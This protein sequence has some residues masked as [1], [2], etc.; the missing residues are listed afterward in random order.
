[1]INII[2]DTTLS[3]LYPKY[4]EENWKILQGIHKYAYKE[5]QK[6]NWWVGW[7]AEYFILCTTSV[8]MKYGILLC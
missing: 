4:S 3:L 8:I 5:N 2:E 7:V 6:T 1:M